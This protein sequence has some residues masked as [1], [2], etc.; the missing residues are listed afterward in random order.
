MM[1][2]KGAY[3]RPFFSRDY[4]SVNLF[5]EFNKFN[6]NTAKIDKRKML[7]LQ[8]ILFPT[9]LH[10]KNVYFLARVRIPLMLSKWLS[11]WL[12]EWLYTDKI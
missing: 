7:S 5:D 10:L 12:L 2:P 11:S 3:K 4:N 8:Y 1:A 6:K 9:E